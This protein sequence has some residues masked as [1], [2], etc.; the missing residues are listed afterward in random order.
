[1]LFDAPMFVGYADGLY[2][3]TQNLSFIAWVIYY[4]TIH[5]VS[6]GGVSLGLDTNN[7]DE[8]NVVIELLLEENSLSIQVLTIHLDSQQVVLQLNGVYYVCH[9]TL[10]RKFI[11]VFPLECYFEFITYIHVP[12]IFNLISNTLTNYVLNIYLTHN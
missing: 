6:S 1:M 7:I 5:L 2:H 8:Y 4:P 3:H 11:R 12:R 9:P 10:L